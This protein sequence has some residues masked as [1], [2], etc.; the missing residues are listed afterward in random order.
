MATTT[1]LLR[2]DIENLGGRGEIVKVKAGYARNFLL[3]K[4]IATLATKGNV[5]QIEVERSALLK[6]AATE[7]STA[8][9]QA[10]QMRSISLAFERKAGEGGTLF[11]SVTSMDV[12]EA[13]Q[14]KGYEIDRRKIVLKDTIKET[15]DYTVTVKLHREVSLQIPVTVTAE[16]GAAAAPKSNATESDSTN[17]G[18]K[19]V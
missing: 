18:E 2:E 19:V 7:K 5:K 12:A 9:A 17:S 10:D 16:G 14:A 8:D 1:I 3:P 13:L 4:G 15:G 6:K 11:G